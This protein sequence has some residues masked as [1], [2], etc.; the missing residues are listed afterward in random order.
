MTI[1]TRSSA[2]QD[3]NSWL[4]LR[5]MLWPESSKEK[6]LQEIDEYLAHPKKCA[7]L[8]FS[9][10]EVAIGFLEISLRNDYVEGA[11]TSPVV[12]LEGI[13]VLVEYRNLGIGT[14]LIK[15]AAKW[16][17]GMGCTELASD[18]EI[19]NHASIKM[20]EKLGF[21]Q[22]NRIVCFVKKLI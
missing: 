18:T 22:A 17:R 6:H 10:D 15:E 20:H 11:S 7:L 16:G 14:R 8:A 13:F 2:P 5:Q 21:T 19:N 9:A 3:K 12:Y 1:T 4:L